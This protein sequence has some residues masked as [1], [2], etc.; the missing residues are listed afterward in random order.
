MPSSRSLS[1][2]GRPSASRTSPD[3]KRRKIRKGTHSCWACKRKKI[4][5]TFSAPDGASIDPE[6]AAADWSLICDGCRRRG[7]ACVRQDVPETEAAAVLPPVMSGGANNRQV[8]DR[9]GRM[10]A[11]VEMLV[12]NSSDKT[13]RLPP[14]GV[15]MAY[16]ASGASRS[17][18]TPRLSRTPGT[19]SPH[20][21]GP[22]RA[23]PSADHSAEHSDDDEDL[24]PDNLQSNPHDTPDST[25]LPASGL[26]GLATPSESVEW[27]RPNTYTSWFGHNKRGIEEEETV[28]SAESMRAIAAAMPSSAAGPATPASTDTSAISPTCSSCPV[29]GSSASNPLSSSGSTKISSPATS[30]THFHLHP[31]HNYIPT[32]LSLHDEYMMRYQ[33]LSAAWPTHEDLAIIVEALSIPERRSGLNAAFVN[34]PV[35][36]VLAA[37]M[38]PPPLTAPPLTEAGTV[39]AA[40]VLVLPPV[41]THLVLVA[42]KLLVLASFLQHMHP[43]FDPALTRLRMPYRTMMHRAV[44]ATTVAVTGNDSLTGSFEGVQCL[45]MLG[46]FQANQG[47]LRRAWL[48]FRRAM[49]MA[50]LMGMQRGLPMSTMKDPDDSCAESDKITN[51]NSAVRRQLYNSSPK[52]LWFRIVYADRYLSL[53][54]G[55]PQGASGDAV[56]QGPKPT[57]AE[58]KSMPFFSKAV[59]EQLR[60]EEAHA[61]IAGR[62][63]ERNEAWR[64][65]GE[66]DYDGGRA[67]SDSDDDEDEEEGDDEA[68]NMGDNDNSNNANCNG[69]ENDGD[70]GTGITT[71]KRGSKSSVETVA[72]VFV[73]PFLDPILRPRIYVPSTHSI[74]VALQRASRSMP[75]RWWLAPQLE[76]LEAGGDDIGIDATDSR[77]MTIALDTQ[78][79]V[80]QLFHYMLLTQLHLPFVMRRRSDGECIGTSQCA[81][82]STGKDG[83]SR[84]WVKDDDRFIYSKITCVNASREVLTRYLSLRRRR[85]ATFFCR[86]LDFFAL[87]AS[88]TLCLTHLDSHRQEQL[89]YQKKMAVKSQKA[90]EVTPAGRQPGTSSLKK[91]RKRGAR[92]PD[93]NWEHPRSY[94]VDD[95]R[96][97]A[98]FL[99]MHPGDD[100]LAHQRLGDRGMM[101]RVLTSMEDMARMAEEDTLLAKSVA[102]LRRML[103][104]ED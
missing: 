32:S 5:C 45:V 25:V 71:K 94:D 70:A 50:Q 13:A 38:L 16:T 88:M 51:G 46:A 74:D 21:A 41:G 29:S 22:P 96:N 33:M 11:L 91:K 60:I 98:D 40:A 42:Q 43:Q 101:E 93:P 15:P 10:E 7:I 66:S 89:R 39:D 36:A 47:N 65:E 72:D 67:S 6:D 86:S 102:F 24:G 23:A 68:T 77:A 12:R 4:R 81:A 80:D 92:R 64:F 59:L 79:L 30:V 104:I 35:S 103:D 52:C 44:C 90:A 9:L 53:M 28:M 83:K 19:A 99:S 62:I 20:T 84:K 69:N 97:D 57:A 73:T 63:N 2:D 31:P 61:V 8:D 100:Y 27:D 55:L 75:A 37:E 87:L 17:S 34:T 54:L 18:R 1:V 95:D 58:I 48:S 3:P 14:G 78:R 76:D 82:A 26:A 85:Q 49:V 56:V